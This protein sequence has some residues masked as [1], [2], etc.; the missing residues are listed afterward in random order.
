MYSVLVRCPCSVGQADQGTVL[1]NTTP[2]NWAEKTPAAPAA[3]I[4]DMWKVRSY[5][6][7][8]KHRRSAAAFVLRATEGMGRRHRVSSPIIILECRRRC[9]SHCCTRISGERRRTS[10]ETA[11]NTTTV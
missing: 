8:K 6:T 7:Q 1:G 10:G 9:H 2:S 5:H 4:K 11:G 3:R